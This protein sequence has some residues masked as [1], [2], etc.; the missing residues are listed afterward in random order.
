MSQVELKKILIDNIKKNDFST[1]AKYLFFNT[2]INVNEKSYRLAEIE[3]YVKTDYHIDVFT[4]CHNQ[5]K[6]MLTWYFHQ[7][8]GK[9]H[10]YKGGTFKGLDITC[11]FN[12]GFCGILIRSVVDPLNKVIEGPCNVVNEFLKQLQCD[13]IKQFITEKLDN[14]LCFDLDNK[15]N[16]L[17]TIKFHKYVETDI[18]VAPRIGLT[19]KGNNIE[20]K[21]DFILKNYRFIIFKDKIKKE[22]KKM[23]KLINPKEQSS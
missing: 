21:K 1:I 14:L 18:Y 6:E 7:M 4:H 20:E 2:Y 23:N 15:N 17:L 19:L 5:Q 22:K 9:E 10:S 12:N 16:N 3:F 13:S 8:S 11:G